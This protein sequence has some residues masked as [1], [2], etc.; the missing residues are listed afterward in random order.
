MEENDLLHLCDPTVVVTVTG[1]EPGA[2]SCHGRELI[3]HGRQVGVRERQ[4]L[5][6]G[7]DG[8]GCVGLRETDRMENGEG[9]LI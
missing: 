5:E 7:D 3:G 8:T 1:S 6:N 4:S 9:G 2:L